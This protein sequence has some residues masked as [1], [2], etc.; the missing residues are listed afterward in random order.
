MAVAAAGGGWWNLTIYPVANTI[1]QVRLQ[2]VVLKINLTRA[3]LV[4]V[5]SN[6]DVV[7]DDILHEDRERERESQISIHCVAE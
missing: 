1:I 7:T 6:S 3:H 5:M 2:S 4:L